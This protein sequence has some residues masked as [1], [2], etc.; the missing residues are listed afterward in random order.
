MPLKGEEVVVQ[1]KVEG[2]E[3]PVRAVLEWRQDGS[4]MPPVPGEAFQGAAQDSHYFSFSLGPFHELADVSYRFSVEGSTEVEVTPYYNFSVVERRGLSAP[5]LL[6]Q[7]E[8]SAW[9]IFPETAVEFSWDNG[10]RIR[11]LEKDGAAPGEAVES[12]KVQLSPAET[13]EITGAGWEV[14]REGA[15]LVQVDF[16]ELE[17][18]CA[19]D[20]SVREIKYHVQTP[21]RHI[22]GLGERFNQVDQ[23]GL[24]TV[25]S[26]V[27][28]FTSQGEYSYIPI[29]FFLT[30]LGFG[31]YSS[32]KRL[33]TYHGAS[34]LTLECR[35]APQGVLYEEW[36]LFGSPQSLLKDL[37]RL[38]G[39]AVLPPKWALGLWISANGWNTQEETL[40]Q[41]KALEQYELP[42]TAMVLEAWSDEHT[43][44]IF[45]DAQYEP[46]P[47]DRPIRLADF[48]FPE[49]GK[50]PDPKLMAEAVRKAGLNLVLW[51]I[52]VI[53]Y[54]PDAC[55]QLQ[56]D[57]AYAIKMGYCVLNEDG[58]PYRI[59]E[60]WFKGSLL[61]DFT[62]PEAVKWWFDKRAYLVKDLG[63]KGFKTD[64]GEFLFGDTTKTYD[65]QLGDTAHNEYPMQYI[66]AYHGFLREHL[67]DGITFSR[68]GHTGAQTVPIHWAGDQRST[69]SELRAQ[70]TAGL[71]AGLSGIP[72][73]SFDM[74]GFAG[75]FPSPELYKRSTAFAALSPVM[76]WHAEPRSGQFFYTDRAR[77]VNDRS[78]WNIADLYNDPE[79]MEVYRLF[80][81]LRMNLLPYIYQE[82]VHCAQS[83]RPLMAHLAIDYPEDSRAWTVHDQ[84]MFG[85]DLLVAP[86]LEEGAEGRRV[87]LPQGTWHDFFTGE[88][89]TGGREIDYTCPLHQVPLFVRDGAVLPV[90]LNKARIMGACSPQGGVS[91]KLDGYEILAFLC[92]GGDALGFQDDLGNDLEYNGG[93]VRGTG[94]VKEVLVVDA[95]TPGDAVQLCGRGLA[96][97]LMRVEERK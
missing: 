53:K 24:S 77:W 85:R 93:T 30:D 74:A 58:T 21:V 15:A 95:L 29:P 57:E 86:V 92:F 20:G 52:P 32:S 26:V 76:Q 75:D 14:R 66:R 5:A 27:E 83:A 62:N 65:G 34:G 43:F 55:Q 70:M 60:N 48:N 51:Q 79:V 54:T 44:Y 69:W 96:G 59:P 16:A 89:F 90:H 10:L 19:K 87:Y 82:A 61:L 97:T 73:W 39:K 2:A 4:P 80:A 28:K 3:S 25:L 17:L 33:I 67:E 9:A 56:D 42:A 18:L 41:L 72:F 46:L 50:W 13:L 47:Q 12:V 8:N 88:V 68:A 35:T 63:V 7:G 31:W 22:F 1:I 45:N 64:G 37:H 40:E 94:P 11:V 36:W 81:N 91:N 78:P 23:K 49:G 6:Y 38:T 84:Y 71:S